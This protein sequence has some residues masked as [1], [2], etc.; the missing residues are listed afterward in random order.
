MAISAAAAGTLDRRM[1][2]AWYLRN[3]ERSASIFSLVDPAAFYERPIQLRHPFAFYEGHLPAFSYLT[4]NQR[5]LLESPVDE[6]LER[7][8]ERG[9]DPGTVD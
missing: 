2:A 7:L 6:R 9:I 4:L 3:R 5:A 1:L 8:F